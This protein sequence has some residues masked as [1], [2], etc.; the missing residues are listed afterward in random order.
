MY[1]ITFF[2]FLGEFKGEFLNILGRLATVILK[3]LTF[4]ELLKDI[5]QS[6][7]VKHT[8]VCYF[9]VKMALDR[10]QVV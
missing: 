4:A 7:R 1:V 10:L 8:E 3:F 9:Q 5:Y 6:G 2:G